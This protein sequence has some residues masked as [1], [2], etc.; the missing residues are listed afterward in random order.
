MPAEQRRRGRHSVSRSEGPCPAVTSAVSVR[1]ARPP[2]PNSPARSVSTV[3]VRVTSGSPPFSP[4]GYSVT[5][6]ISVTMVSVTSVTSVTSRVVTG[7]QDQA[8]RGAPARGGVQAAPPACPFSGTHA[9]LP[10]CT[11]TSDWLRFSTGLPPRLRTAPAT[12]LQPFSTGGFSGSP[13]Q[14]SAVLL[15]GGCPASS[16][17]SRSGGSRRSSS[18]RRLFSPR[19][20]GRL[21]EFPMARARAPGTRPQ[22]PA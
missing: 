14:T 1:A 7:F 17:V 21:T 13:G 2:S 3:T 5:S 19:Q 8:P 20:L 11:A 9:A 4:A 12:G 10:F 16:P 15:P 6:T 22:I 18:D